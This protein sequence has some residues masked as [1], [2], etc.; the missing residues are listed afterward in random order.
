VLRAATRSIPANIVITNVPGPRVPV[1]L[2]G[3]RLLETYPVVPVTATQSL[4]IALLSYDDTLSWG[5][6]ADWDAV[7]DLHDFVEDVEAEFEALSALLPSDHEMDET[8]R[9]AGA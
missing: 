1:Y 9:A 8:E 5:F 2:L 4:G 7:P 3:A 6:N